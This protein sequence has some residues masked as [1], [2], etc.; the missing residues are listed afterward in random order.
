MSTITH[1]YSCTHWRQNDV[2]GQPIVNDAYTAL[3]AAA[4]GG[5]CPIA[6]LLLSHGSEINVQCRKGCTAL[7]VAASECKGPITEVLIAAGADP[8]VQDCCS[9]STPLHVVAN[10]G[11]LQVAKALIAAPAV[12]LNRRDNQGC[13]PLHI[14]VMNNHVKLIHAYLTAGADPSAPVLDIRSSSFLA[15]NFTSGSSHGAPPTR[16]GSRQHTPS[17]RFRGVLSK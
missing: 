11:C 12:D 16:N 7:H 9:G 5:H 10:N 6:H 8:N 1:C 4:A 17:Q 15:N 13:A 14:A 2:G 3:H